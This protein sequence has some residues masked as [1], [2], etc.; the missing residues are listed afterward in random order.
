MIYSIL[1]INTHKMHPNEHSS[2][3]IF[4]LNKCI[5]YVCWPDETLDGMLLCPS[6]SGLALKGANALSGGGLPS[7]LNV[8]FRQRSCAPL[9]GIHIRVFRLHR[10]GCTRHM[11]AECSVCTAGAVH[12]LRMQSVPS[13]PLGLYTVSLVPVLVFSQ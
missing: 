12:G 11:H 1:A 9:H 8:C 5:F 3:P 4:V 7:E 6:F 13:A 10:C 2:W